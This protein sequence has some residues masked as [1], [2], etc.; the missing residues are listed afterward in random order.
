MEGEDMI[1]TTHMTG[2]T[3]TGGLITMPD[4]G[5]EK[6]I[7]LKKWIDQ[8]PIICSG[9]FRI[10]SNGRDAELS[11]EFPRGSQLIS[12]V[13]W[14][15]VDRG[16]SYNNDYR[17]YVMYNVSPAATLFHFEDLDLHTLV[18]N[19]SWSVC[20]INYF[21]ILVIG[22]TLYHQAQVSQGKWTGEAQSAILALKWLNILTWGF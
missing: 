16:R 14:E 3:I 7:E 11:C 13:V 10:L 21:W 5:L 12:N 17:R 4:S 8:E 9:S 15:R 18:N 6:V 1:D 19:E 22:T 20:L 2:M